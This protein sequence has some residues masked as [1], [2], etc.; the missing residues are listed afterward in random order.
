MEALVER[1]DVNGIFK[2]DKPIANIP[3][4]EHVEWNIHTVVFDIWTLLI[5]HVHKLV[6]CALVWNVSNH[7]SRPHVSP[8]GDFVKINVEKLWIN[9]F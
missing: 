9:I 8:L 5:N 2:I 3:T 7:A 4:I 1:N 6:L